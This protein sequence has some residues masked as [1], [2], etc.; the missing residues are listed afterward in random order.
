[1]GVQVVEKVEGRDHLAGLMQI[2]QPRLQRR[3][4]VGIAGEAIR[5]ELDLLV[6]RIVEWKQACRRLDQAF[7]RIIIIEIDLH[8]AQDAQRLC[9]FLEIDDRDGIAIDVAQPAQG[10]RGPDVEARFDDV[11]VMALARPQHRAMSAERDR[12][13]VMVLRVVDDADALH[14]AVASGVMTASLRSL[15]RRAEPYYCTRSKD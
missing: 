8:F 5:N 9:G 7:D 12:L 1:M 3:G 11:N 13:P 6:W 14:G 4:V 10:R 2:V 15:A